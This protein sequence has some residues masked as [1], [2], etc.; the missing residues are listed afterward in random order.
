MRKPFAVLLVLAALPLLAQKPCG[1]TPVWSPCEIELEMAANS[2]RQHPNPYLTVEVWAELRSPEYR[3]YRMPAY[4]DGGNR[5]VVRFTPTQTG[6]W[7]YRISGNLPEFDE[8]TGRVTATA[9]EDPGFIRPA[10]VHH[11][12][13]PNTLR[14]HLYAG[15]TNYSF[16]YIPR[17]DFD[18]YLEA[19]ARQKFTHVRGLVIA[20]WHA[21]KAYRG[22]DQPDPAFFRELDARASP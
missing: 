20:G 8:K 3:T 1:P 2:M 9:S 4:W 19:R 17:A 22:P 7:T 5:L 13:H 15:D 21:Q 6:E 14:P 18:T 11:W 16:A 10:N 12:I